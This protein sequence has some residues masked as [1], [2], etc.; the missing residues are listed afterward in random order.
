[1]VGSISARLLHISPYI[2]IIQFFQTLA[3]SLPPFPLLAAATPPSAIFTPPLSPPAASATPTS[4]GPPAALSPPPGRGG[5]HPSL[6]AA[7]AIALHWHR[8]RGCPLLSSRTAAD[9]PPCLPRAAAALP[10]PLLLAPPP[11]LLLTPWRPALP[12]PSLRSPCRFQRRRQASPRAVARPDRVLLVLQC[13]TG[14][15][16]RRAGPTR[17]KVSRAV[18][19][20]RPWHAGRA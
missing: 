16:G 1:M 6:H 12:A 7:A 20:P 3:A 13:L 4:S 11:L 19:R 10:P 9:G 2:Y 18:P 14:Q 15:L 5:R 8:D 17:L